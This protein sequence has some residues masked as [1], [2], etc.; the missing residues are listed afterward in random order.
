MSAWFHA[1]SLP[2][3]SM[4][5]CG[6]LTRQGWTPIGLHL[7]P[8]THTTLLGSSV[9]PSFV[10]PVPT[11][12][13]RWRLYSLY[14]PLKNDVD[15]DY[16]KPQISDT[17]IVSNHNRSSRS[18]VGTCTSGEEEAPQVP[19]L[20]TEENNILVCGRRTWG[21]ICV[22]IRFVSFSMCLLH[23]FAYQY[24]SLHLLSTS[25]GG[26]THLHQQPQRR[27]QALWSILGLEDL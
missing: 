16:T 17:L 20:E 18:N 3:T 9:M 24:Q 22:G 4:N 23:M 6:A 26:G 7:S 27:T 13:N 11:N 21:G 25:V 5:P 10:I 2:L 19:A 1:L 8:L 15:A 12:A 14:Q